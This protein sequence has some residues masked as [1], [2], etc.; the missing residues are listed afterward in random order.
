MSIKQQ[1]LDGYES[2]KD[3]GQVVIKFDCHGQEASK[4]FNEVYGELSK[5]GAR[6]RLSI[7]K[8]TIVIAKAAVKRSA[9]APAPAP[10]PVAEEP[11]VEEVAPEP[12]PE[13][14]KFDRFKSWSLDEKEDE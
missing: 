12:A 14:E 4:A 5:Q 7:G 11:V 3:G 10:E 6:L 13:P 1:I 2:I 9:P 8:K